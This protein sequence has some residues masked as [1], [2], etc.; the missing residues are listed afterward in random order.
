MRRTKVNT[1]YTLNEASV[2]LNVTTRTLSRHGVVPPIN[3]NQ[4]EALQREFN[5]DVENERGVLR[6][7]LPLAEEVEQAY[8]YADYRKEMGRFFVRCPGYPHAARVSDIAYRFFEGRW[9]VHEI[10]T[11]FFPS[12]PSFRTH[13][14]VE[15]VI[16][17]SMRMHFPY[18]T[19]YRGSRRLPKI[20]GV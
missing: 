13:A 12:S 17:W 19:G 2:F 16:R 1:L 14:L 9:D 7:P 15:G 18:A 4:L 20:G 8:V 5:P 10:V 3:F 11:L 6:S